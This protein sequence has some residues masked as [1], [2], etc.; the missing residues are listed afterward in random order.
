MRSC[1][2]PV[3]AA[4][5][6]GVVVPD[7]ACGSRAALSR[8]LSEPAGWTG[9]R[10]VSSCSMTPLCEESACTNW[11]NKAPNTRQKKTTKEAPHRC[12]EARCGA[13][14]PGREGRA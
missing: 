4:I 8:S 3:L 1:G 7:L 10:A 5:P 13:W 14:R 2:D 9:D 11:P 12:R 6:V